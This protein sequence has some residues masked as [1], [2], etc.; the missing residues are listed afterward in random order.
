LG[1]N[2]SPRPS[3]ESMNSSRN[4]SRRSSMNSGPKEDGAP[5]GKLQDDVHLILQLMRRIEWLAMNKGGAEG[6]SLTHM[7][8]Y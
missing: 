5:G 4:S 7:H 6:V 3:R 1:G 8:M 2:P